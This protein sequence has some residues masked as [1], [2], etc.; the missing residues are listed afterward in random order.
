M[1][2]GRL[3]IR[4][5]RVVLRLKYEK[6]LSHRKIA[7]ACGMGV[8]TVSE[9]AERARRGGLGWPL[10]ADLDDA[11]LEALL[12]PAAPVGRE[13]VLPDLAGVHQAAAES[14]SV[15]RMRP[16]GALARAGP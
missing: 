1:G 15:T 13:R 2:A 7:R 10:R 9:Y 8:G 4:R 3:P 14:S 16:R 5:L 11:A 6:R 12:F